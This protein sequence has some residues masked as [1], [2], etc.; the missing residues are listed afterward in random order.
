MTIER[1]KIADEAEWLR[2]RTLDITSTESAALFGL[3]PYI[4]EFELWHCKRDRVVSAVEQKGRILWGT[5]LQDAIAAG[6]A[7]DRELDVDRFDFYLRD[8]DARMGSSFDYEATDPVTNERGLMEI[9]NVDRLVFF[10]AW[11]E[12][13]DGIE[14]PKHIELQVQHQLEVAEMPWC[15]ITAL[16]GGN[17]AKVQVRLRDREIGQHLRKR[18][19]AFWRSV[20]AGTPP[21]PDYEADAEFIAKLYGKADATLTVDA[22]A[23]TAQLLAEYAGLASAE[24]RRKA[25][26]AQVLERIGVAS[27]VRTAFG[28]LYCGETEAS[29]GT[30][31]TPEMVGKRIGARAGFR[32]FRFTPAKTKETTP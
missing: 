21:T 18:I 13:A 27:R 25:L 26:K 28:S 24:T 22:D 30:L 4:T 17:E 5:R 1:H 8:P 11:R 12:T 6:V 9:K 10:D 2:W 14:A 3:S 16:V 32:Q 7:E 19:A 31:I 29:L 15:I 20:E 23:E